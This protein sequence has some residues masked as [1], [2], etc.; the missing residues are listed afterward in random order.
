MV[1]SVELKGAC[2]SLEKCARVEDTRRPR[3]SYR[4]GISVMQL[5]VFFFLV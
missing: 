3:G 4:L 2:S 5:L 1:F